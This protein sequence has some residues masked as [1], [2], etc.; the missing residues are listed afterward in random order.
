MYVEGRVICGLIQSVV[1]L[2]LQQWLCVC[3]GFSH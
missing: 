1:Q 2:G 3:I